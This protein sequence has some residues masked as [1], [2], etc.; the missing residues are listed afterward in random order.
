[1]GLEIVLEDGQGGRK[2]YLNMEERYKVISA[3]G[4]IAARHGQQQVLFLKDSRKCLA[5]NNS[6]ELKI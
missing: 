3:V 2:R 5:I 4:W 1:M 6:A